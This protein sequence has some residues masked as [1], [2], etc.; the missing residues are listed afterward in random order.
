MPDPH[1]RS[2]RGVAM[3]HGIC[4]NTVYNEISRGNLE[5]TKI[6]ARTVITEDQERAWLERGSTRN[7][8]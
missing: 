5:A 3:R 7:N 4:I 2:V 1:P 8:N 6:G